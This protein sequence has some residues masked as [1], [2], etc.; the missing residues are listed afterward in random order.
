LLCWLVVWWLSQVQALLRNMYLYDTEYILSSN[1]LTASFTA[2]V[3]DFLITWDEEVNSIWTQPF[4]FGTWLFLFNR[5]MP[6][7]D[8][9]L[10]VYLT[11]I[12]TTPQRCYDFYE[13]ITWMIAFG[14]MASE[15]IILLRTWALWERSK[16][17]FYL[18]GGMSSLTMA[19]GIAVTALEIKSFQF[20]HV[21]DGGLGCRLERSSKLIFIAYVLIALSETVVVTLTIKKGLEHRNSNDS[22]VKHVYRHGLLFYLY[23]LAITL[24]NLVVPFVASEP[25]YK[26][27]LAVP[28]RIFHSI[29]C[30]R[31]ILLIQGQRT[32]RIN[33]SQEQSRSRSIS[34]TNFT[35]NLL[36]SAIHTNYTTRDLDDQFEIGEDEHEMST[37]RQDWTQS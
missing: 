13:G 20:G 30:N 32:I 27:Y 36:D 2:L 15:L 19:P 12:D 11:F 35:G 16:W 22:F 10:G 7:V 24:T 25:L 31:V 14:L 4:T 33:A 37:Y 29:F 18:L 8:T 34:K 9:F 6:F 5:Y 21:P 28:Q 1:I 23:L 3:Y 17:V 26:N